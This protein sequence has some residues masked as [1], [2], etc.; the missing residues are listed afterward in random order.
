MADLASP[1]LRLDRASSHIRELEEEVRRL[2]ELGLD[3]SHV[4]EDPDRPTGTVNVD[5]GS[6]GSPSFTISR[7]AAYDTIQSSG[8]LLRLAAEADALCFGTL[9]Q[10]SEQSRATLHEMLEACRTGVKFLDLNLRP[11]CHTPESIEASLVRADG[12]KLNEAEALDLAERYGL[13]RERGTD[14]GDALL[15]RFSL[16]FVLV[17][18]A[19]KG[20]VAFREG[21]QVRM[22]GHM[23]DVVDACGSGDAFSAGFLHAWLR[24]PS[25]ME[26]CRRGNAFG[27]LAAQTAGATTPVDPAEVDRLLS[28]PPDSSSVEGAEFWMV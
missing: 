15:K 12:V 20:S 18:L 6:D 1:M 4:Q 25:L 9:S 2:G 28:R 21:E 14:L 5:V 26:A 10:R 27:A 8:D 3:L 22:S 19:E 23:V 24:K 13:P 17:T 16:D 7:D 11:D